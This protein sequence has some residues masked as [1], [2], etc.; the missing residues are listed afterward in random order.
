VA[1][2]K[3][4]SAAE[5]AAWVRFAAVLELLP[6]VLDA[7]LMRDE[8]LTHFEYFTLAMLSEAPTRTLRMTALAA[9]TNAT[10]PRLSRVVS[11]L[12][13]RGY[14]VRKP[15]PE[16]GRATNATLTETGWEKVVRAAP[17][18]VATVRSYVIDAL[19]PDQVALLADICQRLLVNL[20]PTG[21]VFAPPQAAAERA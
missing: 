1:R 8:E 9:Q 21:R 5:R 10:L 19:S 4:L 3:W 17:G 12:E 18:H 13:A 2:A 16:D 11:R 15:C 14:V 20:D 7:Q 6:G